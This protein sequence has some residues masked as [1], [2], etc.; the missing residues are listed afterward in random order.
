MVASTDLLEQKNL[1]QM[2]LKSAVSTELC[3]DGDMV[4]I[5]WEVLS[6]EMID[7]QMVD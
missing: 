2:K 4:E 3:F 1:V 5:W 7:A 6:V